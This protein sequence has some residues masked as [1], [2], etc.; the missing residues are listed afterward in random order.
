MQTHTRG[1]TL[2]ELLAAIAIFA[3]MSI[4]AYAGLATVLRAQAAVKTSLTR[5]AEFQKAIFRLQSDFEQARLRPIRDEYDDLQP[6]FISREEGRGEGARVEFT[7]GGARN[8][9]LLPRSA[10]E[11]VAYGLKDDELVRYSWT[12]LDRARSEDLLVLPL[13]SGVENIEW[14]FL[15]AQ[16]AWQ[17]SWPPLNVANTPEGSLPK[18]VELRLTTKDWGEIRFLFRLVASA[19]I[20]A[21]PP[22]PAP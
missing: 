19:P 13:L 9:R 14:R 5:T 1:F 17:L 6:A 12:T 11:R 2:I 18:V 16:S 21:A 15:D 4:M 20:Q 7:R 8:P 22:G 3:I 10:L